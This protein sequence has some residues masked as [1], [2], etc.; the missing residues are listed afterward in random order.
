M[1]RSC[2]LVLRVCRVPRR[3]RSF[4]TAR[5]LAPTRAY[6]GLVDS[7]MVTLLWATSVSPNLRTSV[8]IGICAAP[9]TGCGLAA[10]LDIALYDVDVLLLAGLVGVL[11]SVVSTAVGARVLRA[12]GL[13]DLEQDL[14]LPFGDGDVAQDRRR[15]VGLGLSLLEDPCLHVERLGAD[16][17]CLRN[18]LQDLGAGPAQ[19]A[20][21]L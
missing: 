11:R 16:P 6:S 15:D 4:S 9:P 14:L 13:V 12:E 1:M 3:S 21:D 5:S 7:L 20:L 2:S 8:L 18:L 10:G 17:Q 19:A